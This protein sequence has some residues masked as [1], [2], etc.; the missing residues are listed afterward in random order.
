MHVC[1]VIARNFLAH[2][3]VLAASLAEHD[4]DVRCSVLIV[5]GSE[6][7]DAHEPFSVLTPGEIGIDERELA[8]R[9]TM[10][11]ARGLVSSTKPRLLSALLA[12]EPGAVVLLDADGCLY[13]SLA[14]V[15]DLAEA[16]SLVLSPHLHEPAPLGAEI[17]I[18]QIVLKAGVMNG[19]LVAVAPGAEPFLDW[20]AQ[21]TERH[22][23]EDASRGLLLA[24]LWLTLAPVL[25]EHHVLA[26][27]G[28][29]VMGWNLY[30]R[31]VIWARDRASI[32][33][34]PLR[35]FHFLGGFDPEHPERLCP[36]LRADQFWPLLE[37]RPG[38]ARLTRDYAARLLTAG[39][40]ETRAWARAHSSLA[41]VASLEPWMRAA[42][43]SALMTAE[44]DGAEQPPNPIEHGE[45]AFTRWLDSLPPSAR[46][47]HLATPEEQL[48]GELAALHADRQALQR[49]H[50]AIASRLAVLGD[51]YR[52]LEQEH[53]ALKQDRRERPSDRDRVIA[54]LRA[55]GASLRDRG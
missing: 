37:E 55:I 24:Q 29:N 43:R 53:S 30:S 21:R 35:H 40:H 36:D 10:Y 19:G 11:D 12:R 38:V 50:E 31:D 22:C 16:H 14:G 17:G 15:G 3:R 27:R 23:I 49:D 9:A 44:R 33:A 28:C 51:S 42:Y 20:W 48:R 5:D 4:P 52:R 46:W 2:A 13:A 8:R 54:R 39:F 34:T 32:D 25:F 47:A 6:E 1:T 26:D 45:A 41:A 18:E 7:L